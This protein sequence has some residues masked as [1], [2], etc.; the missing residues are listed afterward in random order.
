MW[1]T[2]Y[3][4]SDVQVFIPNVKINS[5][6]DSVNSPFVYF[7]VVREQLV[8]IFGF[9]TI[10]VEFMCGT[11][12]SY[13]TK[14]QSPNGASDRAS[15][16]REVKPMFLRASFIHTMVVDGWLKQKAMFRE[17]LEGEIIA[18]LRQIKFC[19]LSVA[20]RKWHYRE[21]VRGN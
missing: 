21:I 5:D 7:C 8:S 12:Y 17:V 14:P 1:H 10:P 15:N 9:F 18:L 16:M 11:G 19:F 2:C 13:K 3:L 20:R 6:L 4:T